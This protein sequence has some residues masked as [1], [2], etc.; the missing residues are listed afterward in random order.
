MA[1]ELDEEFEGSLQISSAQNI[2]LAARRGDLEAVIF[3]MDK[4]PQNPLQKDKNGNTALHAAAQGGS[5]DVLKYFII[6]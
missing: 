4:D 1:N 6:E 3:L 5:L 2:H